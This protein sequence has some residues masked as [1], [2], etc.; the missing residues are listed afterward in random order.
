MG[1]AHHSMVVSKEAK[2]VTAFHEGGHAIVGLF[3]QGANPVHKA[4]LLPRGNA[5]GMVWHGPKDEHS[6]TKEQLLASLDVAMGGRAAEELIFGLENVTTGASSD[7]NQATQMASR[8]VCQYGMSPRV[9]KVF[10]RGEDV[11]KLSPGMQDLINEETRRLLD[12]SFDRSTAT[13]IA[14]RKELDTLAEALLERE[15]LTVEEIK[16]AVGWDSENVMRPKDNFK[17][18]A[19]KRPPGKGN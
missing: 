13:L 1:R 5:L 12:E 2:E 6:Q 19:S 17:A 11:E 15:T 3:T 7:F 8:M 16:E 4:T 9:G 10:Y 14:R 18:E